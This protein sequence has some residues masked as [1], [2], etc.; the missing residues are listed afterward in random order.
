MY[1]L[2]AFWLSTLAP[3]FADRFTSDNSSGQIHFDVGSTLH[4][5]PGEFTRFT[6]ELNLAEKVTGNLV[7][8]SEGIKTGIGVRD[9]RMYSHCLD[10]G[11]FPTIRFEIRGITGDVDGFNSNQGQGTVNLHGKLSIRSTDRDVIIEAAY[12]W[13]DGMLDLK[14]SNK[15]KWADYGV[16]DPSILISKVQPELVLSFDLKMQKRL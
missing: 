8:Q 7:I 10:T 16:P 5:V 3:A 2:F 1:L 11:Q 12:I 4:N 15:L 6:A 14:G 9:N 13:T